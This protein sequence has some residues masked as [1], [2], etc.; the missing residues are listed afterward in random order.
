VKRSHVDQAAI[1]ER[2]NRYRFDGND[3][4]DDETSA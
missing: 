2:A 4:D 1:D 3:D